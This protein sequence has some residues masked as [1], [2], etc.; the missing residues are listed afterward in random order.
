[1]AVISSIPA[2]ELQATP[3]EIGTVAS[4][5]RYPVK[6]MMGDELDASM[7]AERGLLGD[8]SYAL[9]D[10]ETGRIVSAKNPKKFA[11]LLEFKA[12]FVKPPVPGQNPPA[13]M[14][15]F[16][17]GCLARSDDPEVEAVLS[18]EIG[19]PVRL[20]SSTSEGQ[21]YDEYWPDIE[22][23]RYRNVVTTESMPPRSF[24]D[25]SPVHI[26]TTATL[27][28]LRELHPRGRF[29]PRR[30]RPN[31]VIETRP[32][33]TDFVENSWL[34]RTLR[35]GRA[36]LRITKLCSR[37]VMTTLPQGGLPQDIGILRTAVVENSAHVGAYATVEQPGTI[38]K[39]D[40]VWIE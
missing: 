1:M 22:G 30:F 21:S 11:K 12:T 16:P 6:S 10:V 7:V 23:R 25:S 3:S 14:F 26:I 4:L 5:W 13:V 36:S 28:L 34:G 33:I 29:E 2:G 24:F 31:L 19:T 8:R 40:S 37:C 39:R 18:E 15:S 35:I 17:D 27:A 20:L 32:D 9:Q 38:S